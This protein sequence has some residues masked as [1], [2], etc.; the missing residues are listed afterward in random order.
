M[1]IKVY[2][3]IMWAGKTEW[4]LCAEFKQLCTRTFFRKGQALLFRYN[5][6]DKVRQRNGSTADK[7]SPPF[8]AELH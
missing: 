2:L 4:D 6:P 1:V 8:L 3:I 5:C 7:G